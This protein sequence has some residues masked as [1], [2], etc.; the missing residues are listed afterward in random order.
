MKSK[1][2][3]AL[4]C[5]PILG[6]SQELTIENGFTSLE[7]L[8]SGIK[9]NTSTD[10]N[11]SNTLIGK[12]LFSSWL[13]SASN[14]VGFGDLYLQQN[15]TGSDNVAIGYRA[16]TINTSGK[17]NVALGSN[18]LSG[19]TLGYG[20]IAL[21]YNSLNKSVATNFNIAIGDY[22]LNNATNTAYNIAIGASTMQANSIPGM[23]NIA[24]GNNALNS[25][26]SG[27][28][29]IGLGVG[30]LSNNV[31]GNNNIGIASSSVLSHNLSGDANIGFGL[32]SLLDNL[33]GNYNVAF[34]LQTLSANTT[35]SNSIAMGEYALLNSNSEGAIALG[36]YSLTNLTA[37]IGNI[38][39][40]R[41]SLNDFSVGNH[42][43]AMGFYS[44]NSTIDADKNIGIGQSAL[45]ENRASENIGFGRD[46]GKF[47]VNGNSNIFLGAFADDGS[48]NKNVSNSAAIGFGSVV[49]SNNTYIIGIPTTSAIGGYA[50][51]SNFSDRRLKKDIKYDNTLGLDFITQLKT[52]QYVY[53][54]DQFKRILDGLIAQDVQETLHTMGKDWSGLVELDD[55]QKTLAI[56]YNQLTIPL[57]NATQELKS[58]LDRLKVLLE[59][60]ELENAELEE[61]NQKYDSYMASNM[62]VETSK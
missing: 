57:I 12:K 59:N 6:F 62:E 20:N 34:G 44:L 41:Y 11:T 61:L 35:S 48:A 50:N 24:I 4:V 47:H 37:G 10:M 58:K 29:N 5:L 36:S 54:N 53:K 40:G 28:G 8:P 45:G 15:Q 16:L 33:T 55:E 13:P 27:S 52:A 14:N 1:L 39:I 42:N 56:A 26:S 3:L 43:L 32:Y 18:S 60:L 25:T 7:I 9:T 2:L 31:A 22:S 46:A 23:D 19:N 30:A 51:W 17:E 49:A 38:G 21:G